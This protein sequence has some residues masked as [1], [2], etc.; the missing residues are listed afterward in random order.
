LEVEEVDGHTDAGGRAP[1]EELT[2][3]ESLVSLHPWR[4]A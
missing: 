2:P 1:V 4:S 3:V